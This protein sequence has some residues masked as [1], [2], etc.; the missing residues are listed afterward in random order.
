MMKTMNIDFPIWTGDTLYY[1]SDTTIKE[2]KVYSVEYTFFNTNDPL[3]KNYTT[4]KF[5]LNNSLTI[6]EQDLGVK[7]FIDKK[8]LIQKLVSQL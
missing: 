7:Y 8:E 5:K 2:T 6:S 3:R 4:T 1:I